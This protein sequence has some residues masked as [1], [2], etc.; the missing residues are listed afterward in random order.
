MWMS[1]FIVDEKRKE[2]WLILVSLCIPSRVSIPDQ[3]HIKSLDQTTNYCLYSCLSR[4]TYVKDS[5]LM[6]SY[7]QLTTVI[8]QH[9]THQS[10][11][12]GPIYMEYP[13]LNLPHQPWLF[14]VC[15]EFSISLSHSVH[16]RCYLN[17]STRFHIRLTRRAEKVN[18]EPF[19]F[20][21]S[22]FLSALF[23]SSRPVRPAMAHVVERGAR[24]F[25]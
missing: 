10:R 11:S 2:N 14:V 19:F 13:W 15:E 17:V 24:S 1:L 4:T 20:R 23:K 22:F 18:M 9:W 5:S 16:P 21:L 8:L 12:K 7:I 6:P 3:Q 25:V